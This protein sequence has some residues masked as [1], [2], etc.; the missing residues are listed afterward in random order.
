MG[1]RRRV[2]KRFRLGGFCE[3]EVEELDTSVGGDEHVA[4]LQIAVLDSSI[5]R[6]GQRFRHLNGVLEGLAEAERS[7]AQVLPECFSLEEFA[8]HERRVFVLAHVEQRDNAR[9]VERTHGARFLLESK[10]PR[11]GCAAAP[12]EQR[13]GRHRARRRHQQPR[14]PR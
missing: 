14:E 9:V 5:G 6:R 8:D 13:D 4:G 12:D 2:R 7:C 1:R 10:Q 11:L 3:P